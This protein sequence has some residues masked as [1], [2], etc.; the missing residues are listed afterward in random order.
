MDFA[1]RLRELREEAQVNQKDFAASLGVDQPK[2]NK[3]ENGKNTP[4]YERLCSIADQLGISVDYLLGRT[5]QR[6]ISDNTKASG[7]Q[8]ALLEHITNELNGFFSRYNSYSEQKNSL[9][10]DNPFY[11]AIKGEFGEITKKHIRF[12]TVLEKALISDQ[13]DNQALYEI[14]KASVEYMNS[15]GDFHVGGREENTDG[16]DVYIN[17]YTDLE[18]NGWISDQL[19]KIPGYADFLKTYRER[20][21]L[22][23]DSEDFWRYH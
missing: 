15:L 17:S 7:W 1:T 6:Y 4:D 3:W 14:H 10:L 22:S 23:T 9:K 16:N 8:S 18:V 13:L 12:L 19:E 20:T 21:Y 2:Y 5:N 11:V